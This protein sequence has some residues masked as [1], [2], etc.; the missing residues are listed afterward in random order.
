M[1]EEIDRVVAEFNANNSDTIATAVPHP[2]G[3]V[4]ATLDG[5]TEGEIDALIARGFLVRSEGVLC[6]PPEA[7]AYGVR[8]LEDGSVRFDAPIRKI[9]LDAGMIL[10]DELER[11]SGP[12]PV[13]P[14][15]MHPEDLAK[16][17]DSGIKAEVARLVDEIDHYAQPSTLVIPTRGWLRVILTGMDSRPLT[18]K[19][20]DPVAL[21]IAAALGI[22]AEFGV[23]DGY[24]AALAVQ[25]GAL[26][27]A[28]AAI[29][30]HFLERRR[31]ANLGRVFATIIDK[32][33]EAKAT[34]DEIRQ[35]RQGA[36]GE[37]GAIEG[38]VPNDNT[39]PI[40][41]DPK[42]QSRRGLTTV[43]ILASLV[44][45]VAALV[46]IATG[47]LVGA[48][49]CL[50]FFV[51]AWGAEWSVGV[52]SWACRQWRRLTVLPILALLLTGCAGLST[53]QAPGLG[54]LVARIDIV[55]IRECAMLPTARDKARCLGVEALTK[56]LGFALQEAGKFADAVIA[57]ANPGAGA[58]DLSERDERRLARDAE[59]SF[60]RLAH[61]I[62]LAQ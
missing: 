30:R 2:A 53:Y 44:C 62:V 26:L 55:K 40:E 58:A 41:V 18:L 19:A 46:A 7:M 31:D 38:E 56:G 42:R 35:H 29:V 3:M 10:A 22:V 50:G 27:M 13:E 28:T 61:E 15:L 32:V 12:E 60:D 49:V 4:V 47:S 34:I 16:L 51:V 21:L 33:P 24:S 25:I 48:Y 37:G 57:G 9:A 17:T 23:F 39:T 59:Q 1:R 5:L 36:P 43:G 11:T 45:M 20:Q 8:R 52:A 54:D 6:W 14:V